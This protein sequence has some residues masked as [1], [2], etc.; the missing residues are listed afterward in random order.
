MHLFWS[1]GGQEGEQSFQETPDVRL[2]REQNA[3]VCAAFGEVALMQD[4]EVPNVVGQQDATMPRSI[5]QDRLVCQARVP[6]VVHAQGIDPVAPQLWSQ[7]GIHIFVNE[8]GY[9]DGLGCPFAKAS[10]SRRISS[11]ISARWS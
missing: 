11:S 4:H 7:V 8:Q 10:S 6:N 1:G 3:G 2:L 9:A 5:V